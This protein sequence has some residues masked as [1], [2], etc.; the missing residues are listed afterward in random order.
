M[1]YTLFLSGKCRLLGA[2][3]APILGKRISLFK[4]INGDGAQRVPESC[5]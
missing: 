5:L 3:S 1:A 2:L 4:T